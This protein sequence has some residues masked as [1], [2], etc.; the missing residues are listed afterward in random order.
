MRGIKTKHAIIEHN[1]NMTCIVFIT[2]GRVSKQRVNFVA[3]STS[4]Q[5]ELNAIP[6]L[7]L[8]R[9]DNSRKQA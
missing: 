7:P 3:R 9:Q 5:T 2:N 8:S 1:I 6:L 4:K